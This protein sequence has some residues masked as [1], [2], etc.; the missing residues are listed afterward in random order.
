MPSGRLGYAMDLGA[1]THAHLTVV[2][3][4]DPLLDAATHASGTVKR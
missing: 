4:I 3:V 2:T 1:L